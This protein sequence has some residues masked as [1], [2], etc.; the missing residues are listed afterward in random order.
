[1]KRHD[2]RRKRCL[3]SHGRAASALRVRCDEPSQAT[4]RKSEV[5]PEGGRARAR[6]FD[7]FGREPDDASHE[8]TLAFIADT[9][10]LSISNEIARRV[11]RI[12]AEL[13]EVFARARPNARFLRLRA[14]LPEEFV[15]AVAGTL[16]AAS[17]FGSV[18]AHDFAGGRRPSVA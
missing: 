16:A 6:D 2:G 1:K 3:S 10:P 13:F 9:S 15:Q 5:V 7:S 18:R 17:L 14:R 11:L 12:A 8:R 4:P